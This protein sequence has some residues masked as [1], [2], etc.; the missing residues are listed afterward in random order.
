M[1]HLEREVLNPIVAA[2][3]DNLQRGFGIKLLA[4]LF[5][6]VP[7]FAIEARR[8][9]MSL[10]EPLLELDPLGLLLLGLRSHNP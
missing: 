7:V 8:P 3:D 4:T 1:N 9:V 6:R 2:N 10:D 5:G